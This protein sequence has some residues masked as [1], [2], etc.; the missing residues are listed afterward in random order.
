MLTENGKK[1]ELVFTPTT[2]ETDALSPEGEIELNKTYV[3]YQRYNI[4]TIFQVV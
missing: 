4:K 1:T 2:E 3:L